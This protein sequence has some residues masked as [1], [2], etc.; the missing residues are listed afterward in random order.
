[1]PKSQT[2]DRRMKAERDSN[3]ALSNQTP[4]AQLKI[5]NPVS[6]VTMHTNR[7]TN[8][9]TTFRAPQTRIQSLSNNTYKQTGLRRPVANHDD[10]VERVLA[11]DI[12][13]I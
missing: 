11:D 9:F 3:S 13:K 8:H 10:L 12:A 2:N 4:I 6:L 1:M 7:P 5:T